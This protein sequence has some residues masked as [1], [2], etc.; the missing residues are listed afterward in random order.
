MEIK[1]TLGEALNINHS[2]RRIIDDSKS[3]TDVLLKFRLLGIMKSLEPH[4]TNFEAVRNETIARFGEKTEDGRI[5]ISADNSEALDSFN[6]EISKV[7]DSE[8][9]VRIDKL[10]PEEIFGK[11]VKSEYLIGLYTIIEA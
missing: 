6:R 3:D 9:S 2:L 8:I 10:K 4:I 11:G 7:I 1:M 5:Q